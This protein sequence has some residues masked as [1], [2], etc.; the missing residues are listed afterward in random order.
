VVQWLRFGST[1]ALRI[2]G[3]A[4]R[5]QWTKAFPRFRAVRDGFSSAERLFVSSSEE[6]PSGRASRGPVGR[7]S[8]DETD[9]TFLMVRDGARAPPHHEELPIPISKS[10]A[11]LFGS[12]PLAGVGFAPP[13]ETATSA[14]RSTR[15]PIM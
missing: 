11:A 4:P 12:L 3:S 15:S 5:D 9:C 2:I 1:N 14:G 8:M 13:L 6:R 7:V 10:Q